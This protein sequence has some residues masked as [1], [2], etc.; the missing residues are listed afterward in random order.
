MHSATDEQRRNRRERPRSKRSE[1]SEQDWKLLHSS[2][3]ILFGY[4]ANTTL[5]ALT[6]HQTWFPAITFFEVLLLGLL[7]ALPVSIIRNEVLKDRV[8][9]HLYWQLMLAAI[10]FAIGAIAGIR[11]LEKGMGEGIDHA[12]FWFLPLMGTLFLHVRVT[13]DAKKTLVIALLFLFISYPAALIRSAIAT[14]CR[15]TIRIP[16]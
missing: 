2:L 1:R 4:F 15:T 5:V 11:T 6:S 7:L 16:R 13:Y 14:A 12:T 3:L 10:L 8:D 9:E